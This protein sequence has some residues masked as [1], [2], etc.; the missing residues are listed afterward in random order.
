MRILLKLF[1]YSVEVILV[2]WRLFL[3]ISATHLSAFTGI[4]V[5]VLSNMRSL[6]LSVVVQPNRLSLIRIILLKNLRREMMAAA[7]IADVQRV[8]MFD[9]CV[10]IRP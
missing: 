6:I 3:I 2:D 7:A 1:L 5:H 8:I 9:S 4:V 10:P